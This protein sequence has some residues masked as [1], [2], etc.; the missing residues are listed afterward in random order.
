MTEASKVRIK[1]NRVTRIARDGLRKHAPAAEYDVRSVGTGFEF[2]NAVL[3]ENFC[4]TDKEWAQYD[5]DNSFEL[6][7]GDEWPMPT[8]E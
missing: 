4:L 8:L 6:L 1:A 5:H 3:E 2:S 7:D